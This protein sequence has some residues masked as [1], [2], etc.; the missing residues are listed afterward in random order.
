MVLEEA[1]PEKTS[2]AQAVPAAGD[3]IGEDGGGGTRESL[4]RVAAFVDA[5]KAHEVGDI[6]HTLRVGRVPLSWRA[7]FLADGPRRV[8]VRAANGSDVVFV[9]TGEGELTGNRSNYDADPVYRDAIDVGT[10]HLRAA[11]AGR[12][13]PEERFL[14]A[15]GLAMSLRAHGVEPTSV[16]GTGP[17]A[18]CVAGALAL[19]DGLG[20]VTGAVRGGD[21]PELDEWRTAVDT[22]AGPWVEIGTAVTLHLPDGPVEMPADGHGRLLTVVGRLW[23]LGAANGWDPATRTGGRRVPAPTYPFAA[24]RHYLDAP[25][26]TAGRRI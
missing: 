26:P 11:G 22:P 19:E 17:A 23:E 12:G 6:A 15:V 16:T 8:P 14:A 9:V 18:A 20:L 24:A 7:A 1:P 13:E 25:A 5:A 3:G 4:D 10:A 21:A 2:A